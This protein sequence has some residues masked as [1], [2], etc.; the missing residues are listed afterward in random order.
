MLVIMMI[1]YI[2][3]YEETRRQVDVAD[4]FIQLV[5]KYIDQLEEANL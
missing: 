5:E 4:E 2:A 3:S 1:F